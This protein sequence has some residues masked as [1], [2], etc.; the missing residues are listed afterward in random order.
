MLRKCLFGKVKL[1]M[2]FK[3]NHTG[4]H[5]FEQ[6]IKCTI[7]TVYCP[8][9][10]LKPDFPGPKQAGPDQE[11]FRLKNPEFYDNAL[12][13]CLNCKRCELACP[14][15]VRIADLIYASAIKFGSGTPSLRNRILSG[16]DFVGKIASPLAP[17]INTALTAKPVKKFMDSVLDIDSRRD[18]PKYTLQ[19]FEK[20][21]RKEAEQKQR[22]YSK[23]LAYFHGCYVNYNFPQ[24]GKDLIKILNAAGYGV[25]LLDKEECCGIALISNGLIKKAKAKAKANIEAIRR[26]VKCDQ[27]HYEGSSFLR[28]RFRST[29]K[30]SAP[31]RCCAFGNLPVIGTSSTCIFTLRE[32]YPHLLG[33]DNQDIREQ[34]DLATRFIFRLV[35]SGDLKL[36]FREDYRKRIAY[37][38]ACHMRKL[39][40]NIYSTSLLKMIP[41]VELS[42]LDENCCGIAGT[43]GFKKENY[44]LSQEI[45]KPLFEQIRSLEP[46]CVSSDCETCK[47]QI[48]MSTS[49][50]VM[51]PIS[52]IAE[53]L[54]VQATEVA[55]EVVD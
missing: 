18:F 26:A 54:D 32:E 19:S 50:P 34:I 25:R 6:C 45:G 7:C 31:D 24:L 36:V 10:P 42:L 52:I 27:V 44:E 29:P 11:R 22:K 49:V 15:D 21:Y 23:Q 20:W 14:S 13:Y 3:G 46:D 17:I 43:Y 47:W 28:T 53:A 55:N 41:G 9:V 12:K 39:C 30:D 48:E 33:V 8:V 38:S 35:E 2:N 37:H 16:T 51:H 5:N 1:G 4:E 40:W